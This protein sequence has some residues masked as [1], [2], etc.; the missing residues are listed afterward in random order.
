MDFAVTGDVGS[1]TASLTYPANDNYVGSVAYVYNR[2]R[3]V[4]VIEDANPD[5]SVG[6]TPPVRAELGDQ[7]IVSIERVDQTVSTCIRLRQGIQNPTDYC[8]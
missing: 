4:G 7:I 5:G 2:D 8:N 6:P 3:G 1:R